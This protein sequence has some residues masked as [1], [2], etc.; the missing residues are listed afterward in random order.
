MA[1][2]MQAMP[3]RAASFDVAG[4]INWIEL[5]TLNRPGYEGNIGNTIAAGMLRSQ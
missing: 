4:P 1:D 3:V 5:V 2:G